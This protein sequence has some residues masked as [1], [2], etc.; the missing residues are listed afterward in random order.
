M[1]AG[2]PAPATVEPLDE[3]VSIAAEGSF[4]VLLPYVDI[5]DLAD[6][7]YVLTL[8]DH[9]GNAFELS[10][11]GKAYGQVLAEISKRRDELL[12]RDLLLRGVDLQDSFPAKMLG[13]AE[14][15]PVQ[16]R[17][18]RDLLVVVPERGTMFGVPFS[19]VEDVRWDP[20]LYQVSVVLDDDR[21]LVFGH[22]AK[23]SEEF[24][25]ELRR[26]LEA[27]A[28]RTAA[29]LGA[30][31]PGVAATPLSALSRLMRDGRAAQQREIDAVDPSLWPALEAA[32]PGT[33]DLRRSYDH[34]RS[35]AVPGWSAFGVKAVR[36]GDAADPSATDRWYFC[37]LVRDGRPLN[38]V[39]QEV[40]SGEGHATYVFRLMEPERFAGLDGEALAEAVARSIR[41]LNRA[42]LQLNFRREPLYLSEEELTGPHARYRVALRKLDHLRWAR[43]ALLG[44]AV[45][46]ASWEQ[47]VEELAGRA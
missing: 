40:A 7:D 30:L 6:R 28:R 22:L 8:T 11:F 37:P 18:Y 5:E 39:A 46:G 38:A 24:H 3:Q 10:M 21:A 1:G 16:L 25:A 31:L 41:L 20:E 14:P 12:E 9:E 29:T 33:E 23:R 27:L 17:L 2:A 32:V 36:T 19:F 35:L 42:L 44:R 4:P 45:H 26:L 34:L 15:V 43:S 47:Q 13:G